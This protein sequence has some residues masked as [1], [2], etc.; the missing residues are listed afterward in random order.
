MVI[1]KMPRNFSSIDTI[2]FWLHKRIRL[3][4]IHVNQ[5]VFM[6]TLLEIVRVSHLREFFLFFPYS[7]SWRSATAMGRS[8]YFKSVAYNAHTWSETINFHKKINCFPYKKKKNTL[9]PSTVRVLPT[10]G[11][12]TGVQYRNAMSMYRW[13]IKFAFV[14]RTEFVTIYSCYEHNEPFA[15]KYKSSTTRYVLGFS[16]K[17]PGLPEF[18]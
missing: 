18:A 17:N 8:W 2:F 11:M 6:R 9:K 3:L 12:P 13:Q 1:L 15:N 7:V 14:N 10:N 4:P 16:S 5:H